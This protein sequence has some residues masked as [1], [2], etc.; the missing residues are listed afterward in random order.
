VCVT[1]STCG[2]EVIF[3]FIS[4]SFI[5]VVI[6]TWFSLLLFGFYARLMT[7]FLYSGCIQD[8]YSLRL[9]RYVVSSSIQ[10]E[11]KTYILRLHCFYSRVIISLRSFRSFATVRRV[12]ACAT[13]AVIS[14][15]GLSCAPLLLQHFARGA[16]STAFQPTQSFQRGRSIEWGKP[17]RKPS[18][19]RK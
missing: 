13:A 18:E 10:V 3:K 5:Q 7:L 1:V 17:V 8:S 19:L 4:S 12:M 9:S 14:L 2:T 16:P 6:K 15:Q 11:F